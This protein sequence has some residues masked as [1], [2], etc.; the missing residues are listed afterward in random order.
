MTAFLVTIL[1]V[2]VAAVGAVWTGSIVR[3]TDMHS[4]AAV[5]ADVALASPGLFLACAGLILIALGAVLQ[6]LHQIERNT[7]LAARSLAELA[8]RG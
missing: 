2:I 8:H 5:L 6:H 7:E 4:A 3:G 1:G